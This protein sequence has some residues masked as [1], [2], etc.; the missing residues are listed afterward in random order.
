MLSTLTQPTGQPTNQLGEGEEMSTKVMLHN[1]PQTSKQSVSHPTSQS[2]PTSHVIFPSS[3]RHGLRRTSYIRIIVSWIVVCFSCYCS[4]ERL[5]MKIQGFAEVVFAC[6][7]VSTYYGQADCIHLCMAGC[8]AKNRKKRK[9]FFLALL[10]FDFVSIG[11][12]DTHTQVLRMS[13]T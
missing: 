1:H 6:E 9:L 7:Y 4:F 8:L 3:P 13:N 5:R 2:Y 12:Q 11:D 10:F